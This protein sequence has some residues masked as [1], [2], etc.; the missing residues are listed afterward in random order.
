MLFSCNENEGGGIDSEYEVGE[1][2]GGDEIRESLSIILGK[3]R[4]ICLFV[5]LFF[6]FF[7][8]YKCGS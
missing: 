5:C 3:P 7:S 8:I 4:S 6:F 1:S 2:C